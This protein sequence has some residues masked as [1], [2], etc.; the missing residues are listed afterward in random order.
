[1]FLPFAQVMGLTAMGMLA[2]IISGAGSLGAVA[3]SGSQTVQ[4]MQIGE[5][6][7]VF[8]GMTES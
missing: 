6:A 7:V 8:T 2:V 1:V 5:G 3:R 4:A